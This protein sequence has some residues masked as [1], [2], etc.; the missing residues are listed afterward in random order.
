MEK[1]IRVKYPRPVHAADEPTLRRVPVSYETVQSA[2]DASYDGDTV[3]VTEGTYYENI[4]FRG[5]AITVASQ[6]LIDGDTAH[7]DRTIIDGSRPAIS[8]SGSVVYLIEGEDTSSVLYGLTITGGIGTSFQSGSGIARRGGGVYC[9]SSGGRFVR[10]HIVRNRVVGQYAVGGGISTF[11]PA[12]PPVAAPLV[13]ERNRIAD[14]CAWGEFPFT[15]G[16]GYS[17]GVDINSSPARIVGNVF[18][19][20]TAGGGAVTAGGAVGLSGSSGPYP[21]AHIE[22]NIF[23]ANVCRQVVE[24]FPSTAA[25]AGLFLDHAG[26]VTVA[27]NLFE[28]NVAISEYGWAGGGG[29]CI[30]DEEATGC[31]RKIVVRNSFIG[32]HV[33]SNSVEAGVDGRGGG[34]WLFETSATVSGNTFS[35]NSAIGRGDAGGGGLQAQHSSFL[36]ENNTFI[37]NVVTT[38]QGWQGTG[39]GVAV[40]SPPHE[41]DEQIISNN[42]VIGNHSGSGGG[43]IGVWEFPLEGVPVAIINN[44]IVGNTVQVGGGGVV[45][46]NEADVLLMNNIIRDNQLNEAPSQVWN[47]LKTGRSIFNDIQGG[48]PGEGNIDVPPRFLP[49]TYSLADSSL[50]IGAGKD[51]ANLGLKWFSAPSSDFAGR[52]RPDPAGTWPDIGAMEHP[53]A[54]PVRFTALRMD[55]PVLDF[56][57]VR[58][59]MWSDT[60]EVAIT[61]RAST[62]HALL[63]ASFS[64]H[65]FTFAPQRGL[66]LSIAPRG[67]LRLGLLFRP[68]LPG[69]VERDSLVVTTTDTVSGRQGI[70]LIGRGSDAVQSARPGVLYAVSS[71]VDGVHLYPL[72]RSRGLGGPGVHITPSPP[73]A[74]NGFTI[75]P[76][77]QT[78]HGTFGSTT[79]TDLYSLSSEKGDLE[80]QRKIPLENVTAIAYNHSDDLYLSTVQ[81]S[82]YRQQGEGTPVLVGASGHAFTGLAFNPV[83]E[84]LWGTVLDS[85]FTVDQISGAANLIGTSGW[86]APRSAITFNPVGT[87]YGVYGINLVTIGQVF[88]EPTVVGPTGIDNLVGIAMRTDVG[89]LDAASVEELP[90]EFKLLQNCPNPF[91]PVTLIRFDLPASGDVRIAVCDLLG[92]EVAVLVD[93]RK[94]AGKHEVAFDGSSLA[95]GMYVYRMRSGT[96]VL[97][98]KMMVIK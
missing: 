84:V 22:G 28:S 66:P 43:G 96:S 64:S 55:P 11:W 6:Y 81:G 70:V 25:G 87:L 90:R 31:G 34:V 48:Y 32:N 16:G 41:G 58:P 98:R 59:G 38:P 62:P 97:T 89:S 54:L 27:G 10:N 17:G 51:S 35:G 42:L 72:D 65:E 57:N 15:P 47:V 63:S 9:E 3:L 23:R 52:D 76:R 5:K 56:E 68:R 91:N 21:P 49:G 77:S 85:V 69:V 20:D 79:G 37:Q 46:W 8:D 93:E 44:T 24:T 78:L 86:D 50:C 73:S 45:V 39:G 18:E 14:N 88:G 40:G 4:R 2:I 7:I 67:T 13:V 92:R 61:N 80:F 19:R 60:L 71:S 12:G 82:L 36:V 30:T 74:F 75:R 53:F 95:S 94:S 29:I 33:H 83:T 1:R 26:E